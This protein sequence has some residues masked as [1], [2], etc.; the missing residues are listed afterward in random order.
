M[1]EENEKRG[2]HYSTMHVKSLATLPAHEIAM[3]KLHPLN[4]PRNSDTL[5]SCNFC[6]DKR[7]QQV[8]AFL[9]THMHV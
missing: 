7:E 2:T 3:L 9:Q 8:R 4:L 5:L 6:G 1:L